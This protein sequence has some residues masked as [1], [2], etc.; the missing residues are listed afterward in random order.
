[1]VSDEYVAVTRCNVSDCVLE[2]VAAGFK[3]CNE[4]LTEQHL[5]FQGLHLYLFR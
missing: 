5:D 3:P 1:M 2:P 4:E